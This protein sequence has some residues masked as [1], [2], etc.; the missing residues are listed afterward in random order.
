MGLS[1]GATADELDEKEQDVISLAFCDACYCV[2]P[3]SL[4]ILHGDKLTDSE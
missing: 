1:D 3:Y 4:G 2:S